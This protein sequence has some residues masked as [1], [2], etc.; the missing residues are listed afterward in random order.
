M[1]SPS[2]RIPISQ[3]YKGWKLNTVCV[4]ITLNTTFFIVHLRR[5]LYNDPFEIPTLK[6]YNALTFYPII[7]SSHI[8]LSTV[9]EKCH[10]EIQNVICPHRYHLEVKFPSILCGSTKVL[11][12]RTPFKFWTN[13]IKMV[14]RLWMIVKCFTSSW[15]D[16]ACEF[17][18]VESRF[19]A[20]TSWVKFQSSSYS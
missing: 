15:N 17:E 6:D 12:S 9:M 13:Q 20:R 8:T 19:Y 11:S 18:V 2:T 1:P 7:V 5:G 3:N 4:W 10:N 16:F 14:V